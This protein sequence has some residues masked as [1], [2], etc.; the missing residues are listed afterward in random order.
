MAECEG[1]KKLD[2][3]FPNLSAAETTPVRSL[4]HPD[5][6]TSA[7]T[8]PGLPPPGHS[9]VSN[10]A[11]IPPKQISIS[12][13]LSPRTH[14]IVEDEEILEDEEEKVLFEGKL[15]NKQDAFKKILEAVQ[16]MNN[17]FNP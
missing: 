13:S 5:S 2:L 1:N 8:P 16:D 9:Q 4:R 14:R 3:E 6:P 15:I 11:L 17:N 12:P 7:R 10:L